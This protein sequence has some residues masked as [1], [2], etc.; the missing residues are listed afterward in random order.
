MARSLCRESGGRANIPALSSTVCWLL[1][2]V[3]SALYCE[4]EI[5]F[6]VGVQSF[7]RQAS[8]L[9]AFEF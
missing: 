7:E 5:K 6:G 1:V 4:T 3:D 8:K 9:V 2:F